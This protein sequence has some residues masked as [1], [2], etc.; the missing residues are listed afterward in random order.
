MNIIDLK[1]KKI[2]ITGAS[3]GIGLAIAKKLSHERAVL[4]LCAGSGAS[5][6]TVKKH[7]NV[8]K[9]FYIHGNLMKKKTPARLVE[10]AATLMGG[11]DI[12]INNAGLAFAKAMVDTDI[13]EWDEIMKLNARAPFFISKESIQYLKK[14]ECASIINISSVVGNKG[15][16]NQSAYSAS[17][18][19]LMG[20]TKAMAKELQQYGIRVHAIAPGGVA[21]EMVLRTRPDLDA[22]VLIETEEIA[23]MV[24]YLLTRRGNAV[25]D[26]INIRRDANIPFK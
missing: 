5:F 19:A 18:H 4:C 1:D 13:E 14:S 6:D 12:L 26:E 24:W 22:S 23:D 11:I 21:T 9:T 20:F 16:E 8:D 17:K 2:L 25:I 7:F 15:Y 10:A 3:R